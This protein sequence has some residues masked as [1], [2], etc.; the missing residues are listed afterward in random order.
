[1]ICIGKKDPLNR[2]IRKMLR[3]TSIK[4]RKEDTKNWITRYSVP[5]LFSRFKSSPEVTFINRYK[6]MRP[7]KTKAQKEIFDIFDEVT[8]VPRYKISRF[9]DTDHK[10]SLRY[11]RNPVLH[12]QSS[13][14]EINY[15]LL[16]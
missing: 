11:N 5:E 8:A 10:K 2:L 12:A 7:E 4:P 15:S 6:P 13:A 9:Y 1:M 14:A 16:I 3:E